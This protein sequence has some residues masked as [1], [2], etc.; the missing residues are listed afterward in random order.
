MGRQ[1]RQ[2]AM[3]YL[4]HRWVMAGIAAWLLLVVMPQLVVGW[5]IENPHPSLARIF[6]R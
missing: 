5:A 6:H 1:I 2:V 4:T 3:T